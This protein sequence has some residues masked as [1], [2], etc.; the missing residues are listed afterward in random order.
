MDLQNSQTQKQATYMPMRMLTP[1][2][3]DLL[4]QDMWKAAEWLKKQPLPKNR[5][6]YKLP[7]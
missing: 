5:K 3:L 4:K 2:E 1:S 7:N 6:I